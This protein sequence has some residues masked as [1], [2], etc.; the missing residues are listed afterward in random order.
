MAAARPRLEAES[1]ICGAQVVHAQM[2]VDLVRKLY[3]M[4]DP[5]TAQ[6]H[7]LLGECLHA[8]ADISGALSHYENAS[9]LLAHK[10]DNQQLVRP[11][12]CFK[13]AQ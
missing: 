2:V 5:R 7:V 11:C 9:A 3:G 6:S 10:P 13:T 1:R 12:S 4:N 8:A